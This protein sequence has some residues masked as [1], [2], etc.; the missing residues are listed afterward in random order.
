MAKRTSRGGLLRGAAIVGGVVVIGLGTLYAAGGH[1]AHVKQS[2][3]ATT[4]APAAHGNAKLVVRS[5]KRGKFAV[6][7]SHLQGN[8]VYDVIV[9][10]V[11]VG[12]IHTNSGG[13]GKASF[14]T[15]PSARIALLGFDPRGGQVTVRDEDDGEDVLVGDM[16]DDDP[17]AVA[18]CLPESGDD[19]GEVECE[20]LTQADCM[21]AGGMQPGVSGGTTAASCFP[22]PCAT[23]P[24][25]G[26]VLVCCTNATHD[27]ESEAE[28][29]EVDTQAE[30]ADTGGTIVDGTSCDN[31]P[32]QGTP[33]TDQAACCVTKSEDGGSETECEVISGAACT[34]LNGT[35]PGGATC[36]GD[37]CGSGGDD[38]GGGGGGD[39]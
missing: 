18:C 19:D 24:P 2:L 7:A 26:G 23:T 20:D 11:K 17:N 22:N 28:C 27:D 10:G 1:T 32:C 16:P 30:C 29:E 36:S 5:S 35:T 15:K 39:D 34:A 21:L 33:P 13:A 9:G 37:P 3:T 38:G 25:G 12:V 14:S 6:G 4:A 8:K 31:N